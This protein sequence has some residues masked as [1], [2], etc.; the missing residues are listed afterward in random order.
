M[1]YI[2]EAPG[3][4]ALTRVRDRAEWKAELVEAERLLRKLPENSDDLFAYWLG[5]FPLQDVAV[6][7]IAGLA[8]ILEK[9]TYELEPP[10]ATARDIVLA[11][12][13]FAN[14]RAEDVR[15]ARGETPIGVFKGTRP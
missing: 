7:H 15:K 8:V 6:D 5:F 14:T 3:H 12:L 9:M 4:P 10:I 11:A 1:K 13:V 2:S